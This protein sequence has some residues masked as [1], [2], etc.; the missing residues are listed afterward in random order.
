MPAFFRI[1]PAGACRKT[2]NRISKIFKTTSQA[3]RNR[4]V[5][6]HASGSGLDRPADDR[7]DAM[8]FFRRPRRRR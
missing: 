2:P 3:A 4:G 7:A 8:P 5:D 1:D 6:F